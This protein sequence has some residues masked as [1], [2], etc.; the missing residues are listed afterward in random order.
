MN[1]SIPQ[2]PTVAPIEYTP[3]TVKNAPK[4]IH[5]NPP[6]IR[7]SRG[8]RDIKIPQEK[9]CESALATLAIF[10][11]GIAQSPILTP[12]VNGTR[13]TCNL[14]HSLAI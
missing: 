7:F 8:L 4:A 6:R 14:A 1:R 11:V 13:Y 12:P 2:T 10:S 9:A 3:P 5:R